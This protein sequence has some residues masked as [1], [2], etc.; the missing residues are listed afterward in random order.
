M[1]S[2]PFL[3]PDKEIV[4]GMTDKEL[5]A[6]HHAGGR[7]PA[8]RS[9]THEPAVSIDEI[10]GHAASFYDKRQSVALRSAQEHAGAEGYVVTLPE[11]LQARIRTDRRHLVWREVYT[12]LS[13]EYVGPGPDGCP[14][15]MVLHG[16]GLL[17]PERMERAYTDGLTET[18]ASRLDDDEWADLLEGRM[19]DGTLIPMFGYGDFAAYVGELPRRYGILLGFEDAKGTH[20]GMHKREEFLANPLAVARSGGKERAAAYFD[21]AQSCG[22]LACWYPF[23]KIDPA[24]AQGRALFAFGGRLYGYDGLDGDS[25]LDGYG[26][27]LAVRPD[28]PEARWPQKGGGSP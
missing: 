21:R 26:R 7:G 11:L 23:G 3:N 10:L 12:T 28:A 2:N 8:N 4:Q 15:V 13:E 20:S 17:T 19:P 5:L 27:F 16:G 24:K 25:A 1:T 6:R 18:H 22:K 9:V 14:V